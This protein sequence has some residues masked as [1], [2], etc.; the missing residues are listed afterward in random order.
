MCCSTIVDITKSAK[1][2]VGSFYNYFDSKEQVFEEMLQDLQEDLFT[3]PAD[4]VTSARPTPEE[5]IREANRR[6]LESL[7]VNLRGRWRLG[8]EEEAAGKV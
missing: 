2:A 4:E 1:V 3:I 6:Y 8:R 5:R 7:R